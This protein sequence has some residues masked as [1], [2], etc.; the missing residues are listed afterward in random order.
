MHTS[1]LASLLLTLPFTV[2]C[3]EGNP[4]NRCCNRNHGKSSHEWC[5]DAFLQIFKHLQMAYIV[6]IVFSIFFLINSTHTLLKKYY[7]SVPY[8]FSREDNDI[9]GNY[10]ISGFIID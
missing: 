8:K 1:L 2:R 3:S 4:C 9:V 7:T 5:G 10:F 6:D